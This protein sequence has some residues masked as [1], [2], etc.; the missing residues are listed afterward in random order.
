MAQNTGTLVTAAIRPNDSLDLIASAF[1]SEI[2]GGLHSVTASSDMNAIFE[3]RRE[4]GM[5]CHV[6]NDDKTY[7]L[8]YNYSSSNI[9]DNS[10]W[11]EFSGSGGGGGEWINSVIS[12]LLAE[13]LSPSDGDRYLVGT[14]P[15][16]S[17]SGTNWSS[18]NPGIVAQYSSALLAW[19]YTTP[20]NGM[21]VRVDDED[22]SIYRYEGTFPSGTWEKEK[23]SQVRYIDAQLISGASY[24]A[25]SEPHL[26]AYDDEIIYIVRFDNQNT[27]V[28]ASI[29]INGLS[30]TKIKRTNGQSLSDVITNEL[31]TNYSYIVTYNGTDFELLDPSA[32]GG[33]GLSN[34]YNISNT[35]T[36]TV[37]LSTQY[38]IYGD[39]TIDGTLENYGQVVV[40]N[41]ALNVSGTFNNYGTY[42]NVYFAEINGLGQNNYVPRWS[43]PYLLTASSSIYDDGDQVSI[44][45]YTFSVANN[46]VLPNGASSGYILTSN[47]NG[48]ATWQQGIRKYTATQSY[49]ANTTYSISHNLNSRAIVYNFWN[50]DTGEP[51]V[52]SVNR[53]GLNTIDVMSTTAVVN[54]RI[55][56]IS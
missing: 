6:L 19:N 48:V 42:S 44:T 53:S 23:E 7:Q 12:V 3:A 14:D 39:L 54:G 9:M 40:A 31:T 47:A 46:I 4:W 35:E 56:I 24:S 55:V 49:G 29:S 28:S 5:L 34:Q 20:T 21:S 27:G 1:A 25:T 45:S 13:P 2:K 38:W 37:P 30:H 18:Q 8:T 11:K 52:V 33:T 26:G 16:D 15:S 22:N 41:G 50:D 17:I 10:N 32:S 36:V 43:S 51:L